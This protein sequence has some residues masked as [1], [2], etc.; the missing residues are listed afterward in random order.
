MKMFTEEEKLLA[1]VKHLRDVTIPLHCET[2][3]KEL[4]KYE[5]SWCEVKDMEGLEIL[6]K[7]GEGSYGH[8][9]KVRYSGRIF[10]LKFFDIYFTESPGMGDCVSNAYEFNIGRQEAIFLLEVNFGTKERVYPQI[11]RYGILCFP[12]TGEI[13]HFDG[14]HP[15]KKSVLFKV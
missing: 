1:L 3:S 6:E 12:R 2:I 8:V 5:K 9:Y 14:V 7:L 15:R 11:L 13:L 4:A 10:A